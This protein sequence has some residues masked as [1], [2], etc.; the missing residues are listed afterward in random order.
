[1]PFLAHVCYTFKGQTIFNVRALVCDVFSDFQLHTSN[2]LM[3]VMCIYIRL[4]LFSLSTKKL[5]L[6]NRSGTHTNIPNYINRIKKNIVG[7]K[8]IG[9]THVYTGLEYFMMVMFSLNTP[10]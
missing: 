2:I 1:M 6:T 4:R 5:A 7:Q 8:V 10:F 9:R 3:E